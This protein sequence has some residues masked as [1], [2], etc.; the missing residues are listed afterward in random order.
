[1]EKWYKGIYRRNLVDMHINDTKEEYLSKFSADDYFRYL[2]EAKIEGPMIYLQSHTGLC[3][4]ETKVSKEHAFFSKNPNEIRKLIKLCHDDGM[5]VVGY[6]SLIFNNQAIAD[7]PEWEMINADGTT[8]RDHGQRYGLVCPNNKEYKKFLI[9]Q[10][11][12]LK[13]A[14]PDIDALFFDMPYWEV[15]CHCDSCKEEWK[16]ISGFELPVNIDW[17]NPEWKKYVKAR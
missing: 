1:M 2:K 10:I 15:A 5:K 4:Y 12:E 16:K 3:N 13:E 11:N 17:D 7:H 6:Y 8:W 14:Y 9:T